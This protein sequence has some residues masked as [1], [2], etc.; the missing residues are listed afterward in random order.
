ME[1]NDAVEHAGAEMT[2]RRRIQ[3]VGVAVAAL[4]SSLVPLQA[5][6]ASQ[7]PVQLGIN[8][9]VT[10]SN[11]AK[12]DATAGLVAQATTQMAQFRSLG[13][14]AVALAFPIYVDSIS[15]NAVVAGCAASPPAAYVQH[16]PSPT[17]LAAIIDVAH[18]DG[19]AVRLRPLIDE[20]NLHTPT[21]PNVWRGLLRPTDRTAWFHSYRDTIL[22]YAQMAQAHG[23]EHFTVASELDSLSSDPL[24]WRLIARVKQVF[25]RDVTY[26]ANWGTPLGQIPKPGTTFGLDA[27]LGLN[28]TTTGIGDTSTPKALY[29]AWLATEPVSPVPLRDTVIDEVGISASNGAYRAPY[30]WSFPTSAFNPTIQANWFSMVCKVVK[31][32]KMAGVYFWGPWLYLRNGAMLTSTDPVYGQDIQPASQAV[33]HRC[34][35]AL[36]S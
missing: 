30:T 22:P 5:A 9:Y 13:A 36:A 27:Y 21:P 8:T 34:F 12:P 26:T 24:W 29:Q 15:A 4:V 31:N 6:S 20:T 33:I 2:I 14:N 35:S 28:P 18:A 11:C 16:S 7:A 3:G 17:Q 23:V 10:Y 1:C 19:L 32:Q 25:T